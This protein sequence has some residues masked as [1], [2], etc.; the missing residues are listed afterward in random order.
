MKRCLST[1]EKEQKGAAV[2]LKDNFGSTE[3]PDE[4]Y[5][6]CEQEVIIEVWISE[7]F[8]PCRISGTEAELF[9]QIFF[10]R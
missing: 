4:L 6:I 1:S 9:W 2:S 3:Y 10:P 7:F 5:N 8:L